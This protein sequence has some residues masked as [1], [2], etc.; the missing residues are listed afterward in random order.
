VVNDAAFY[1]K[2]PLVSGVAHHLCE[3]FTI[4]KDEKPRIYLRRSSFLS[5]TI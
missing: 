3:G 1:T 5:D 4:R 2:P